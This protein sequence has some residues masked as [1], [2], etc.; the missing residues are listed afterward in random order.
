MIET[1]DEMKTFHSIMKGSA[2]ILFLTAV[3]VLSGCKKEKVKVNYNGTFHLFLNAKEFYP[4][5]S[6]VTLEASLLSGAEAVEFTLNDQPLDVTYIREKGVSVSFIMPD[7][8]ASLKAVLNTEEGMQGLLLADYYE[9]TKTS[10]SISFYELVVTSSDQSGKVNVE[11]IKKEDEEAKQCTRVTL[12]AKIVDECLDV[13]LKHKIDQWAQQD[14]LDSL[15]G[16]RCVFKTYYRGNMIKVT[17]D[18]MIDNG[19][20]FFKEIREVL[21]HALDQS[22]PIQDK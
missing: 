10:D 9:S 20:D 4:A 11:I 15:D 19:M 17:T 12:D 5:Q 18:E 7:Q 14:H 16:K 22:H 3:F 8:E 13:C 1:G 6:R 21:E 2:L